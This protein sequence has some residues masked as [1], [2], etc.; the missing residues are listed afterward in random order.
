MNPNTPETPTPSETTPTEPTPVTPFPAATPVSPVT[1]L[2]T[3]ANDTTT[4]APEKKPRKKLL[5]G[6]IITGAVLLIG[7]LAAFLIVSNLTNQAKDAASSYRKELDTHL[8]AVLDV[9]NIKDRLDLYPKKPSLEK[10]A[11]GEA[12]SKE[13]KEAAALQAR[14]NKMLDDSYSTVAERYS[15]LELKPWLTDLAAALGSTLD[16][17]I[18]TVTDEASLA[19]A[20]E[21]IKNMETKSTN[22]SEL[23]KRLKSYTYAQKYREYQTNSADALEGMA[24]TWTELATLATDSSNLSAKLLEAQK[25]GDTEAAEKL[26][27]EIQTAKIETGLKT[28]TISRDYQKY[29]AA[30]SKNNKLLVETISADKYGVEVY[31]RSSDSVDALVA[32]QKE[33]K[34]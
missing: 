23:A 34:K 17:S 19:T 2:T 14:Y 12:L 30:V 10:V 11:Q 16:T 26:A 27:Q 4:V 31:N 9:T 15:T 1:P 7:A 32:F 24:K 29:S 22:L 8:A 6:L 18:V 5:I 20:K 21:H 28:P 25:A 13:Y 3:P 33:I